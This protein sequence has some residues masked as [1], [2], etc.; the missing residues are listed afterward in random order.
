MSLRPRLTLSLLVLLAAPLVHGA[1]TL[2]ALR[3]A[4]TLR[5]RIDIESSGPLYQR[6]PVLLAVEIATPR[7]FS[8][9][10]RVRDFRI[11]GAVVLPVSSFAN[12]QTRTENGQSWTVQRWRFR[13]YAQEAGLLELPA[14]QVFVSVNHNSG[15]TVEG[16]LRLTHAPLDIVVPPG[17]EASDA[18]LAA[19]ALR[20]EETW[21]GRQETYR[22]GDAITRRRRVVVED[23]PGMMIPALTNLPISGLSLYASSPSVEDERVRGSLRGS[24]SEELVVT[25]EAAGDY[26]LPGAKMHWFDT[27]AG[28]MRIEEL[29]AYSFTV[30][31]ALPAAGVEAPRLNFTRRDL[32]GGVLVLALLAA[33]VALVRRLPW[34]TVAAPTVH[35]LRLRRRRRA[36]LAALRRKDAAHALRLLDGIQHSSSLTEAVAG[37][38]GGEQLLRRLLDN[39]YGTQRSQDSGLSRAQGLELWR[40]V[41][42]RRRKTATRASPLSLNPPS[43]PR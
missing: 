32:L 13:L 39:A 21:T 10:T 36:Y 22:V 37:N 20:V 6:A 29:A 25:L 9:G 16:E 8:R 2:E 34:R 11:P 33:A 23:A 1:T 24:R 15:E 26:T 3:A 41:S 4:D 40:L 18:W 38:S 28:E 12:N 30:S 43:L 7:W 27:R 42:P 17:S 19:T 31:A 14:L 35:A 5:A